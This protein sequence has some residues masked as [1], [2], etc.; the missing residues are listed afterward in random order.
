VADEALEAR[1]LPLLLPSGYGRNAPPP[2]K[3]GWTVCA[4]PFRAEDLATGLAK[5]LRPEAILNRMKL[6]AK[7]QPGVYI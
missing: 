6:I 1:K 5:C 7:K 2:D 4:K 3:P